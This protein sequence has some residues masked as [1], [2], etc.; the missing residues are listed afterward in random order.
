MPGPIRAFVRA[1]DAVN[2]VIGFYVMYLALA[3][4]GLLLFA[5]IT[6]YVFNVPFVWIIEMAQ[7]LMAAYYILGGG[8]S[9]QIDAHVRMDVVYERWAV[10]TRAFVD[11]ITAFCLVFYLVY[12]VYGGWSSSAYSLK[13][14][15][16]NYSAWAPPM[17]PIKIIMTVGI[18]LM[19][20]QAI[21]IFFRDIARVSGREME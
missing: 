16:T 11:S 2:R 9:L 8:Y 14:G 13:Y 20:L 18:A 10:K 21:A 5:S 3:M 6:R 1:V 4:M 19:L 17:A 7:F 15:Q 12:M